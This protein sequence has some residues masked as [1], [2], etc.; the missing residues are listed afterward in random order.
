V[1]V[2]RVF[3][4]IPPYFDIV[5]PGSAPRRHIVPAFTI[6]YGILSLQAYLTQRC[7][8]PVEVGLLD[9]N[10]HLREMM[11]ADAPVDDAWSRLTRL[12]EEE[13]RKFAPDL[14]GVSVLFS[15][16]FAYL[17]DVARA[18]RQGAP[19]A[20]IVAGGGM[21]SAAYKLVL[22][23]CP[24][25]DA[26]CKGEGEIPMT[27]LIGSDD[28]AAT[29]ETHAAWVTRKG[30]ESGKVPE[31]RFVWDLDQIPPLDYGIV[32]LDDYNSRSIDKRYAGEKRREMAIHTSRGCPFLCVF[33]SNPS[34]HGR[35]VRAMSVDRV[36][37]EVRGMKEQH[38]LTVLLIEDDHFFFDRNRAKEVLRR[39]AEIGGVRIEFPNGV[40][41]YA[42]DDETAALLHGAGVSTV[43]LAVE[44]GSDHVLN[45]I[46]RKPL[47]KKL[48]R[49]AVEALRK[50]GVQAHVFVVIGLP[51]ELPEH[52]QETLDML[53]ENG[54]DWAHIYCAVPIF[55]SRLYELCVENGYLAS[56]S[57]LDL[58]NNRSVIKAPGVDPEEI[59]ATA[60]DMNLTV[61]FVHNHN[62]KV[63]RYDTAI[64][65][66][67][68]V[69]DK[70]EDHAFAH[71]HLARAYTLSGR[72]PARAAHHQEQFEAI[73]ARDAW[74]RAHC[75]KHGLLTPEGPATAPAALRGAAVL[76]S[77]AETQ[78]AI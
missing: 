65:Y 67:Q 64:R 13:V 63:G 70:Y 53:V 58:V 60:Y 69:C 5:A 50:H 42:I 19:A 77:E 17:E 20:T 4:V 9:L 76:A 1:S 10:V 32:D 78:A 23:S 22:D 59:A 41:V 27:E 52:R 28:W 55:G 26:V 39:L 62:L 30:A 68:N 73:V 44:S 57:T 51:G 74:W 18:S 34:L 43:A 25:I 47:K 2:K 37:S 6:P 33:C 49:P 35:D 75:A 45:N 38:G 40:A 24:S 3:F 54:F 46:I 71:Y 15:S 8:T 12:V 66:F 14:V 21:P 61:N 7:T 29:L 72:D 11:A 56:T 36:V 16:S 48:I 31:H